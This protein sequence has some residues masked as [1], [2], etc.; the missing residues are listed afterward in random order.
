MAK[1]LVQQR[2]EKVSSELGYKVHKTIDETKFGSI[3]NSELKLLCKYLRTGLEKHFEDLR[4]FN[5]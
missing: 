2:F 4:N 1:N 3:G 5:E